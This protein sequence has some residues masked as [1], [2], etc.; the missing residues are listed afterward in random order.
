M[1]LSPHTAA[2]LSDDDGAPVQGLSHWESQSGWG[3]T[4]SGRLACD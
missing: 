4:P 1:S 3:E 2:A